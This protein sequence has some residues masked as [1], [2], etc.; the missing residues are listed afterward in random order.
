MENGTSSVCI[1][2]GQDVVT[3]LPLFYVSRDRGITWNSVTTLS[4]PGYFSATSCTGT[5][6]VV[7]A[8][9]GQDS[10]SYLPLLYMSWNGG[11]TWNPVKTSLIPGYFDTT[12][13]SLKN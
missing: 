12:S 9:V 11:I 10:T 8:A 2:V 4:T 5:D 6:T 13:G 3:R 1:A 7:C